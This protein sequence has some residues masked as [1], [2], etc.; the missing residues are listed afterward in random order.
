MYKLTKT[1]GSLKLIVAY[2]TFILI[3][4]GGI[5]CLTD[6]YIVTLYMFYIWKFMENA[7]EAQNQE[8]ISSFFILLYS[9]IID[10]IW[11]IYWGGKWSS[12]KEDAEGG[13]HTFVL[14]LSFISSSTTFF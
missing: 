6:N 11:C 13:I 9:L 8:K 5:S 12:L 7:K 3:T 10:I 14:I 1:N 2:I 4:I